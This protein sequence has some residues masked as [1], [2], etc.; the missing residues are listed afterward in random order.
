MCSCVCVTVCVCV[1]SAGVMKHDVILRIN[2]RA[3]ASTQDVSEAVANDDA[4]TV[5]LKRGDRDVT[6]TIIPEQT[7]R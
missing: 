4:L 1:P 6:L 3:V 5:M 2:G 7:D